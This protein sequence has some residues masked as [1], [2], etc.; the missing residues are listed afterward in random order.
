MRDRWI[1]ANNRNVNLKEVVKIVDFL[2]MRVACKR[3]GN[4]W[5]GGAGFR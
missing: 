1:L 3:R 5:G 2:F 4:K